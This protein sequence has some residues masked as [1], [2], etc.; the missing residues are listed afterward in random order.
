MT[1]PERSAAHD[2]AVEVPSPLEGSQWQR[3]LTANVLWIFLILVAIVVAFTILNASFVK[4]FNVRSI[5]AVNSSLIV[6]AVGETFVIITAGIDL[7]VGS[8]LIFSGVIAGKTMLAFGSSNPDVAAAN[9]GWL[10]IL[11]GVAAG[12][13]AGMGFGVLNGFLVAKAKVPP[14]I[15]TLGTYGAALGTSYLLTNGTDLRGMPN[16][17]TSTIGFGNLFGQ[18]PYLVV[19]AGVI[20]LIFGGLLAFTRFGRYTYAIGSN[21]EAA[22]RVGINVSRHL[23]KVYALMGALAGL[24]GCMSL[25][26]YTTTTISGH[27]TDNLSAIAA[28]VIGGSSLFGGS[29]T[30]AGTVIGVLIPA[31]LA[32][33]FVI[34]SVNPYWQYVAVGVVLIGAV[35]LDQLRRRTREG[36]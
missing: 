2:E 23:I 3:L 14:L 12:V 26:L 22:R 30:I 8:V 17:L 5:F 33:G 9:E 28:V 7:S 6:L 35:Y 36:S 19:I 27:T 11:F 31:T 18:I 4:P 34:I 32:S 29:G 21:D 1:T 20:A 25:A 24:A 10:L 16:D 15:V 13:A